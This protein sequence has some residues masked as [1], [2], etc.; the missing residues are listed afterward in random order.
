LPVAYNSS[1]NFL[2]RR[3]KL[4]IPAV[5]HGD[6]ISA[7]GQARCVHHGQGNSSST[8]LSQIVQPAPVVMLS[9]TTLS[10]GNSTVGK[11]SNGTAITLTNVGDAALKFAGPAFT[12]VGPNAGDFAETDNCGSGVAYTSPVPSFCTITVTFTPSETG[13]ETATL[14]ITDNDNDVEGAQ[15]FVT[16]TGSGLS[17][18]AGTSLYTDAIFGTS[19]ACGAISV[20]GGSSVD[21]FNSSLGYASS[22][23]NSGGNIGSNGNVTLNGSKSVIYG[24]AALNSTTTGACSKSAVSGLTTNDGAQVTGGLVPLNGPIAYPAPPAP[25]PAPP[26]TIQSISG[27]CQPGVAGCTSLGSKSIALAPGQYGN[28]SAGGGTS[29]HFSKGIYNLN[30]LILTGKSI[31]YADSGPVDQHRRRLAQ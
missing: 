21:S 3:R 5:G 2:K 28:L 11:T 22:Q 18:I 15:Q 23:Q 4:A 7:G 12:F 27:T 6:G 8:G 30:S 13:V 9:P 24:A 19:N 26:T 1:H 29:L 14:Q 20:S 10:F 31:L 17:T 16:L 25:N